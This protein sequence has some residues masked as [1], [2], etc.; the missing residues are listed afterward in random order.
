[1]SCDDAALFP[2]VD[3]DGDSDGLDS[4]GPIWSVTGLHRRRNSAVSSLRNMCTLL[5]DRKRSIR[6]HAMFQRNMIKTTRTG[7]LE[8]CGSSWIQLPPACD[9]SAPTQ[10]AVSGTS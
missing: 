10:L 4:R 3:P 9:W 7:V 1:M 2:A 8:E 5:H 6:H